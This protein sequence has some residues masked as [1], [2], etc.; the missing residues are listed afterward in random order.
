VTTVFYFSLFSSAL[1][2]LS[3]PSG[4]RWPADQEWLVLLG[5]GGLGGLGQLFLTACYKYALIS[6]IAPF[7]YATL[8][9]AILIGVVFFDESPTATTL[10]GAA[11]IIAVGAIVAHREHKQGV[12]RPREEEL[13]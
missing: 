8:I 5:I 4:W 7:E 10:L 11:L 12:I 1:A 3:L 2:L 13:S 9:W 6:Q